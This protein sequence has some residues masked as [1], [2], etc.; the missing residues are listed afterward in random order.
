MNS[1][2]SR[3]VA[4][5]DPIVFYKKSGME[6]ILEN[7]YFENSDF[8]RAAIP[9]YMLEGASAHWAAAI[10]DVELRTIA[11]YDSEPDGLIV[12]Q[13]LIIEQKLKRIGAELV[14]HQMK[15]KTCLLPSDIIVIKAPRKCKIRDIIKKYKYDKKY[16]KYNYEM[17]RWLTSN[18]VN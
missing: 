5:V 1:E 14:N 2:L 12:E 7:T 4:V 13:E 17:I 10:L 15:G 8:E 9:I 16:N 6:Y 18:L 3:P 11:V